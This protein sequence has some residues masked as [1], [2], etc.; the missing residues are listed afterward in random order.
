VA[1]TFGAKAGFITLNM[2]RLVDFLLAN[3]IEN[4]IICSAINQAGFQ[5][6]PD[7]ESYEAALKEKS[8]Q[9][10]AMSVMAAGA[11]PPKQAM[12]YVM[13]LPNIKSLLFGASSEKNILETQR[14]WLE[15]KSSCLT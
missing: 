12:D 10:M 5:M 3:G 15:R 1:E 11:I 9:P 13:G 8:F 2:P 6:N 4:P 7:R 14:L